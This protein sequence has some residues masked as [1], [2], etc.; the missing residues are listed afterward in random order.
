MPSGGT[1]NT[2]AVEGC[3]KKINARGWC[4][5]HYGRWRIHGTPLKGGKGYK[6]K[7]QVTDDGLRVCKGCAEPKPFTEFHKDKNAPDGYRAQ[8]KPC[9]NAFMKDY[10]TANEEERRVAV[11]TYRDAN[12][13]KVRATDM[14]RYENH[15]DKRIAL[16]SE[17]SSVRRARMLSRDYDTDITFAALR[18]RDGDNCCYCSTPMTYE[19]N[20]RGQRNP[21]KATIEHVL[22]ISRGGTH[23]WDNVKLACWQCNIVK[24]AR[25]V[26]EWSPNNGDIENRDS[27]LE[28]C[29]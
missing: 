27:D 11:Q 18:E 17:H 23:T 26:D 13:D 1:L 5:M 12:R 20:P 15:K 9:R 10:Y 8:C 24:N 6:H 25:T 14:L 22:P 29:A 19:R 2:C 28:A 3:T 21:T 4:S 16:A 7:V